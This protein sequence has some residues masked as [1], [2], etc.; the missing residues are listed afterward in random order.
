M[1]YLLSA[2]IWLSASIALH[3]VINKIRLIVGIPLVVTLCVFF[4][5]LIGCTLTNMWILSLGVSRIA[6]PYTSIAL[7]LFCSLAYLSIAGAPILGYESPTTKILI[8]LRRKGPLTEKQ[9]LSLFTYDEV[10]GKRIN[11]LIQSKWIAEYNNTFSVT[12]RGNHI[13]SF[14]IAYRRLLRLSKGG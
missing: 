7:Y 5:G 9:I 4:I 14:F 10:I 3:I 12:K 2:F 11:G 6:L 8:G 13:A 1:I